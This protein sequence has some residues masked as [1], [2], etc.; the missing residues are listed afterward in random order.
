MRLGELAERIGAT[1][2]GN[3]D[4]E[5]RG[6]SGID[7]AKAGHLTLL[8]SDKH[9]SVLTSSEAS[10]VIVNKAV[11]GIVIPQMISDNPLLAFARALEIFYVKA[12]PSEGV[13]AGA[14]VSQKAILGRDITVYPTAYISDGARIGDGTVIY[15][16]VFIGRDTT[17]GDNCLIYPHVVIREEIEVGSRVTIHPGSV[18]G[19]DGYGYVMSGGIHHKIPQ[20]GSV[21]VEDDV[22]IGSCVTIDRATTGVTR[23]GE[24]TKIDNLV[25]IAHNV[26]IGK[27]SI[28]I[29]QVG[30][31][32]SAHVGDHVILAGQVGVAD[33]ASIES[34]T[35]VGAK[36]GVM[37]K[38]TQGRYMGYIAQP[39]REFFRS[40]GL[41]RRLPQIMQQIKNLEEEL[42]ELKDRFSENDRKGQG[43]GGESLG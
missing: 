24:G 37:G 43:Q 32:G 3:A 14:F 39:Y 1:L 10:A 4:V 5:I 33:H 16:G 30:I 18:I 9:L 20:V 31:A 25:Q 29:A 36:T 21:V 41:F 22:E 15:P 6:V 13:M 2:Q 38:V 12:H 26:T 28:I 42:S 27:H 23:V 17:L 34:Q 19:T 35:V 40:H 7:T 11:Q 8:M